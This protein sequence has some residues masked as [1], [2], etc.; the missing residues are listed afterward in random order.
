MDGADVIARSKGRWA[1]YALGYGAFVAAFYLL[2]RSDY[3]VFHAVIEMFSA[4]V[5]LGIFVVA[6]STRR[7][8]QN[9]YLELLSSGLLFVGLTSLAHMVAYKGMGILPLHSATSAVATQLWIVSRLFAGVAFIVAGVPWRRHPTRAVVLAGFGAT[10]VVCMLTIFVW[11]V[12]P[13]MFV[14]G[15]GLTPLKIVLEYVVM[16]MLAVASV[17]LWRRRGEFERTAALRLLAAIGF[18]ILGELAFTLYTDVYGILNAAGHLFVLLS[19]V[20]IYQ[21]LIDTTLSRP[22]EA[23]FGELHRKEQAEARIADVLQAAL[24][25]TPQ[26]VGPVEAGSAYRSATSG[27]RIGGDFF[28][29]LASQEGCISFMLGDVCG[30]GIEAAATTAMVRT[31]VR[32]YAYENPTP[33]QVMRRVNEALLRQLTPD[34]FVTLVYGTIDLASGRMLVASAGHPDPLLRHADGSAVQLTLP[35]HPPLGIF[36][37]EGY[38]S[39]TCDLAAGDLL[40]L[41]TDGVLDAGWRRDPFGL[42]RALAVVASARDASPG[43]VANSLLDAAVAYA[44]GTLSDDISIM[45]LR[46]EPEGQ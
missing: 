5:A 39:F 6:W 12:F 22:Y 16:A 2:S 20:L 10:W 11:P 40:V 31:T 26:R 43:A 29:L 32:A 34:R 19:S 17:L 45:A 44:G 42:E 3:L 18:M 15:Q 46:Y 8:S 38:T 27:A 23:L 7:I 21:A 14:D 28:E 13:A 36:P 30:K 25:C 4:F 33:S 41:M 35:R 37:E 24:V 9:T 1:L